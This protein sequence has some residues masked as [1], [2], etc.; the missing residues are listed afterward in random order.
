[1]ARNTTLTDLQWE[2][3]VE[4]RQARQFIKFVDEDP[5]LIDDNKEIAVEALDIAYAEYKRMDERKERMRL[6]AVRRI[7]DDIRHK[8]QRS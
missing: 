1:M 8:K 4:E 7:F 3:A 6:P 2:L 5:N